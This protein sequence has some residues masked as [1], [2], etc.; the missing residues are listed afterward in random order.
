MA[1]DGKRNWLTWLLRIGLAGVFVYAGAMKLTDVG[2]LAVDI[3]NYR[4]LPSFAVAPLAIM[5]PGIE[6]VAG[7]A[8]LVRGWARA[9]AIVIALMLG[10]FSVAVAQALGRGI[11]L[12]C[13]CF[14]AA[15]DPVTSLTLVRDVGLL[16]AAVVLVFRRSY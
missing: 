7:V 2:G 6:L 8:L 9:A 11:S 14:G 1:A 15:R 5:L 13:G 12:E 10:V 4:L 3:A 16:A